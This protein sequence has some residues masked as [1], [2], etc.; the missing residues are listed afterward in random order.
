M[1]RSIIIALFA[2]FLSGCSPKVNVIRL[3]QVD[4]IQA[5]IK[6]QIG[7][8]FYKRYVDNIP[9]TSSINDEYWCGSSIRFEISKI[10]VS[11]N[12][13]DSIK[14]SGEIAANI[15]V[16]KGITIGPNG[17]ISYLGATSRI[18]KYALWPD[19]DWIT[20]VRHNH[21]YESAR[22][23]LEYYKSM[24]EREIADKLDKADIAKT[25]LDLSE[26]L[27]NANKKL[28]NNPQPCLKTYVNE[29]ESDDNSYEIEFTVEANKS[30][31]VDVDA[32]FIK[33]S[34]S[35]DEN[36]VIG[37]TIKVY[38]RQTPYNV[39]DFMPHGPPKSCSEAIKTN[40]YCIENIEVTKF[41]KEERS[42][43]CDMTDIKSY[44][45]SLCGKDVRH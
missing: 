41:S 38:F 6:D 14:N 32:G 36:N 45:K 30:A 15:P 21:Q 39:D 4:K 20:S 44:I 18:L 43:L 3:D 23:F 10:E 1:G 11:L 22:Y 17:G 40:N 8:Y 5:S 42:P 27:V 37:N 35:H 28:S 9:R 2:V 29:G 26:K 34:V 33:L 19:N 13:T 31:G 7:L 16:A 12:T 24:P 25:L